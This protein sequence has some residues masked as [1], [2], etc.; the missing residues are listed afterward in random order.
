MRSAVTGICINFFAALTTFVPLI[1]AALY[2]SIKK[3]QYRFQPE[4]FPMMKN[5]HLVYMIAEV[6]GFVILLILM[7]PVF[8]YL[9]RKWYALPEQ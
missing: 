2:Y 9:Y 5:E 6:A 1:I 3:Q 8:T 4:L 7:E